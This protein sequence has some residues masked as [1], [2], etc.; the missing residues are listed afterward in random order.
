M[1]LPDNGA[2]TPPTHNEPRIT[3]GLKKRTRNE[4][5]KLCGRER[6]RESIARS[7]G[8]ELFLYE[9]KMPKFFGVPRA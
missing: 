4:P 6:T 8:K 5:E 7:I 1:E 3:K 2:S 9:A